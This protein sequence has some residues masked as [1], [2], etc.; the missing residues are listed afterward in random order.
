MGPTGLFVARFLTGIGLASM[1]VVGITYISE[2]FPASRRGAF[3]SWIMMIGLF[4]I[5]ATA[6]VARYTIPAATWGWRLIFIWGAG[7][8]LFP[9]FARWLHESPV[10]LEN[11]GR[12]GEAD[13]VLDRMEAVARIESGS[14]RPVAAGDSDS[15][16]P[17]S[18]P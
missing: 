6:F 8:L 7:G 18:F 17:R 5:P 12:Y 14:L 2:I 1:T 4:G 13:D 11:R 16:A 15:F 3:Q 9:V 10:W